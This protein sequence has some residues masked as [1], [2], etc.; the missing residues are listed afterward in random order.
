MGREEERERQRECC[1]CKVS[2]HSHEIIS[3]EEESDKDKYHMI[4]LILISKNCTYLQN[5]LTEKELTVTRRDS[6]RERFYGKFGID[7]YTWLYF[8]G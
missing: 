2:I 3:D 8:N 7:I 4:S 6:V 5:R 1:V